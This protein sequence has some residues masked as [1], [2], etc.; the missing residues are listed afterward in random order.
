MKKY[1]VSLFYPYEKYPH[2]TINLWDWLLISETTNRRELDTRLEK[3]KVEGLSAVD[4]MS[5]I[6]VSGVYHQLHYKLMKPSK[7]ICLEFHL[8]DNRMYKSLQEIKTELSKSEYILYAGASNERRIIYCIVKIEE[9]RDFNEH[10]NALDY[11]FLSNFDLIRFGRNF[12][13][14]KTIPW[15]FDLKPY[16]NPESIVYK[17]Q[18]K[19]KTR[20]PLSRFLPDYQLD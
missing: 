12:G 11:Y 5:E 17:K 3:N 18:Q 20:I 10:L 16:F 7:L 14:S 8:N 9:P 2:K 6:T 19:W 13:Y 15:I 4:L 1:E